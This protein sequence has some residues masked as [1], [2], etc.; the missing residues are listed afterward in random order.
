MMKKDKNE[1]KEKKRK[2]EK[3]PQYLMSALNNPMWNYKVYH[4]KIVERVFYCILSFA[5]GGIAG[6]VFYGNLF[7]KNGEATMATYIS[8]ITIFTGM[9][10]AAARFFLPMC[11]DRISR[12]KQE[13]LRKQFR[14]ML[15]SLN[16]TFSTGGNMVTA[17]ENAQKDMLAQFGEKAYITVEISEIMAGLINNSGIEELLENFSQRSGVEDIEDF[18]TIFSLCYLKGGD[19]K[20]VVRNTYDLIGEKMAISEE[21]QTKLTSN[22]MQQNIMSVVPIFMIGFLRISS[23]SFAEKFASLTGVLTMTA[24]IGIFVASY[25][26]GRKI[27]DI[28]G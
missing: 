24:A 7:M 12:K 13:E 8:N 11:A 26:Y 27:V 16:A 21:I 4:L 22:K 23:S 25:L 18:A 5:A 20:S 10:I 9:G 14:E 19:M 3:E 2:Q 1:R 6:L 17:F 15:A 28:K